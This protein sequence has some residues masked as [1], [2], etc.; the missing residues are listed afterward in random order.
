MTIDPT[1]PRP[2]YEQIADHLR[3]MITSGQLHPGDK[4]PSLRQLQQQYDLAQMTIR[5][6]INR[7]VDEG[8]IHIR[9]GRGAFVTERPPL[10]RLGSD[11]YSHRRQ[12]QGQTPFM[13]DRAIP[14]PPTFE[15]LQYGPVP[16]EPQ[17]AQRLNLAPSEFVLLQALRLHVGTRAMQI[18]TAYVPYYL[19]EGT[20]LL[21]PTAKA[22][23]QDTVSNLDSVGVHVDEISEDITCRP[24]TTAEAITLQLRPA[25]TPVF[26]VVRTM[27]AQQKPVETCDIIMPTDRYLLSYRFSVP[28]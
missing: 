7:L 20:E 12:R 23:E 19:V 4:L 17:I 3:Q 16:A 8:L 13:V 15:I 27:Y 5:Q 10:R 24:A 9:Q 28:D 14:G 18:S 11:R 22:W 25:V 1:D 26:S 21:E 6:A 2:A